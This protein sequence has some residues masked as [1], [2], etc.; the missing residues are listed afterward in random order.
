MTAQGQDETA[1]TAG[2]S[3]LLGVIA[4]NA[5]PYRWVRCVRCGMDQ[6]PAERGSTRCSLC[7]EAEEASA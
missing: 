1:A 5:R 4:A 3:G 7:V 6:I 2:T